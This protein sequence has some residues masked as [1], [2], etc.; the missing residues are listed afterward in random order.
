MEFDAIIIGGGSMG[1]AAAYHLTKRRKRVA[2]IDAF[3]PPHSEG[4]HHGETRLIRHAYG[5]GGNYVPLALR[6][7]TL[8]LELEQAAG[9]KLFYQTGVLNIGTES[10]SFLHNVIE[11]AETHQLPHERLTASD[12]NSRW[13]GFQLPD[14]LMG[15][16]EPNSG[17]LLSE[18]I[19][20]AYRELAVVQGAHLMTNTRVKQMVDQ[21][22]AIH[23]I[24]G[25]KKFT[26]KQLIVTAGKGT[27]AVLSL[28]GTS[29]PLQPVRKTFS[30]FNAAEA[31]YGPDA[32]PA[33]SFENGE[34]TYY[35]FPSIAQAGLKI[36]RHD[37]G[38]A[39]SAEDK[40]ASFGDYPEDV[41]E[42][43]QFVDRHMSEKLVHKDGKIC[44][45]TNTPDG[46]F[47]IDRLPGHPS[48]IV[49]C[50]FSGHGFK[51]SSVVGEILSELV[52]EGQSSLDISHFS[53]DRFQV[54]FS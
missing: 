17:V 23:I 45:Y 52:T 47:V 26:A 42:V 30:W 37:R 24:A 21:E 4:S 38:V 39:V 36:G 31:V 28:L 20:R 13:G 19:I 6:A 27:N 18:E 49:A 5:E 3:D 54:I 48:V 29:L 11:S 7:Q 9:R 50:G 51:F 14:S 41:Q 53:L 43:T 44:T 1:M 33:W 34:S 35:G 22:G 16:F 8:W 25:D 12:I 2:V 40:L 46:D 10:S 32:F 15:C